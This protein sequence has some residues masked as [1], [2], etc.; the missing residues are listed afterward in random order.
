MHCGE[1][2]GRVRVLF[3]YSLSDSFCMPYMHLRLEMYAL[4]YSAGARC[5]IHMHV[6]IDYVLALD[7]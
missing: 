5:I 4:C 1:G 2:E 7:L 3:L 6:R